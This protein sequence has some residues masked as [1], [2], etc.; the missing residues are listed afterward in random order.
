MLNLKKKIIAGAV[1]AVAVVSLSACSQKIEVTVTSDSEATYI[2]SQTYPKD[3]MASMMEVSEDEVASEIEKQMMEDPESEALNAFISVEETDAD[4]IIVAKIPVTYDETGASF[5]NPETGETTSLSDESANIKLVDGGK[6]AEV[7]LA[8]DDAFAESLDSG[9]TDLSFAISFPGEITS[10]EGGTVDTETNTVTWS[11]SDIQTAYE[12]G[13]NLSAVGSVKAGGGFASLTFILLGVLVLV[14]V[15]G[16]VF[17]A[18]K[19]NKTRNDEE[20][21]LSNNASSPEDI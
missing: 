14:I 2:M 5:V 19:R 10:N 1:A 3:M 11:S 17:T 20:D 4:V 18:M 9:L 6:S 7:T 21:A 13:T 12:N 16:V 15:G 8:V